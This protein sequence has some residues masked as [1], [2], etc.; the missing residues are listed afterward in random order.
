MATA[1]LPEMGRARGAHSPSHGE[2]QI[3]NTQLLPDRSFQGNSRR[4]IRSQCGT[5][6]WEVFE[7]T[8]HFELVSDC[9]TERF[10]DL[11]Q[12]IVQ[13]VRLAERRSDHV[14]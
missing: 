11:W 12:G 4:L 14:S 7:I 9:E 10:N 1:N 3:L 6:L 8:A 2:N 13:Q 5:E